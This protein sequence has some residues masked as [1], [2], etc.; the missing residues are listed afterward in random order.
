M[1]GYWTKK[2]CMES[3][4]SLYGDKYDFKRAYDEDPIMVCEHWSN[5]TDMMRADG[6]I[7]EKQDQ[8][9]SHPY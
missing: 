9:W 1:R 5:Y 4:E 3:F 2:Q 6:F 7:S 8:T